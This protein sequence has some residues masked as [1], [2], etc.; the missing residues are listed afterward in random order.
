MKKQGKFYGGK[1]SIA[2][3]EKWNTGFGGFK[4]FY[5]HQH[6]C[7]LKAKLGRPVTWSRHW[8]ISSA[9]EGPSKSRKRGS[10]MNHFLL[11]QKAMWLSRIFVL[12][13]LKW[14][15]RTPSTSFPPQGPS[16]KLQA[17]E[18]AVISK[19]LWSWIF[20]RESLLEG[21][22]WLTSK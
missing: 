16:L 10:R 21:S 14:K 3:S 5:F 18:V 9:E 11:R 22:C 7:V 13:P 1:E 17:E 6:L 19:E 8:G 20:W 15:E 12:L 2:F 4:K